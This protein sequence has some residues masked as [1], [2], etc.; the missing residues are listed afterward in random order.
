MHDW[1]G[2]ASDCPYS[3]ATAAV[4]WRLAQPE[5]GLLGRGLQLRLVMWVGAIS[6][7]MYLWHWPL[8]LVITPTRTGL[9]LSEALLL[10]AS[11]RWWRS[12]PSPTSS[13]ASRSGGA[14]LRSPQL[15]R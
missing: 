7:E 13:S 5:P 12:P 10:F 3:F 9:G 4:L 1:S 8:Y 2:G 14:R 11:H 15:A 6:Y